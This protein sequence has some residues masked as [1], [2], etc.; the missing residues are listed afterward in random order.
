MTDDEFLINFT[1][2]YQFKANP[3]K[4]NIDFSNVFNSIMVEKFSQVS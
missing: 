4:I 2:R 1:I 3:K